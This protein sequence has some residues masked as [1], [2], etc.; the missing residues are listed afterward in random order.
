MADNFNKNFR[1][2]NFILIIYFILFADCLSNFWCE[3]MQ[4]N[5]DKLTYVGNYKCK[6]QKIP[7]I[8][9]GKK[10]LTHTY[11]HDL[12]ISKQ[13]IVTVRVIQSI[14]SEDEET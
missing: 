13:N 11:T 14:N 9:A 8:L 5:S 4:I 10:C 12:H 1:R 3:R 2:Q 7:N 6:G